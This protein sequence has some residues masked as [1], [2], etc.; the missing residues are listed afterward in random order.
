MVAVIC[1]YFKIR[2]LTLNLIK[3]IISLYLSV[4]LNNNNVYF[5]KQPY[6]RL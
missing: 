4:F 1:N 6:F 3:Q 5:K 2:L